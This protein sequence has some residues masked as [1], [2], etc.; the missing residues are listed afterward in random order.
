MT[1]GQRS[2][3]P[4]RRDV[5]RGVGATVALPWLESLATAETAQQSEPPQRFACFYI[6]NGVQ[7]WD[8]TTQ[9][10]DGKIQFGTGLAVLEYEFRYNKRKTEGNIERMEKELAQTGEKRLP[11]EKRS[12]T[13]PFL[14]AEASWGLKH[15][16]FLRYDKDTPFSNVL[17]TMLGRMNLPQPPASFADS[18]GELSEVIS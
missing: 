12:T 6:A 9:Q 5:L 15:G 4:T 1:P 2:S 18:T 14:P 7:G 8:E 13:R 10:A 16:Q 11:D 17:Y 3:Y